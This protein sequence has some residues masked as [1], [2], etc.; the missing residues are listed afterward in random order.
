M[1]KK[2]EKLKLIRRSLEAG[3]LLGPAIRSAGIK[4]YSCI[5]KWRKRRPLIDRYIAA[6]IEK[7]EG[8]RIDVVEDS[9]FKSAI[10]GNVTAQMFFLM[11]RKPDR[12]QD[13][14]AVV[15]VDQSKHNHYD[16]DYGAKNLTLQGA[17]KSSEDSRLPS[18]I[19]SRSL[20]ETIRQDH[21]GDNGNLKAGDNGSE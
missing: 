8:K 1:Y 21:G 13:K 3:K 16:F 9:L 14:R 4:S 6:C 5:E 2:L 20:R 12:W 19:H 11:N 15:N 7:C 17:R 18:E 10:E